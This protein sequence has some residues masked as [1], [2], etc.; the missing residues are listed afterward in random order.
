[1]KDAY[2]FDIS[3]EGL[4]KS[5]ELHDQAYRE[6]FDRCGLKYFIVGLQAAQWAQ[7]KGL[8]LN[9]MRRIYLRIAESTSYAANAR[10]PV[11]VEK[12][13]R[14]KVRKIHTPNVRSN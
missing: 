9:R 13:K 3:P 10:W 6:I 7:L 8:W 14:R 1:M 11:K 12:G 2:S 4:D 5:Y